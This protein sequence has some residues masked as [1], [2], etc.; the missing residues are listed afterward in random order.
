M[1]KR[2][3]LL[4]FEVICQISRPHRT[5][6]SLI[7]TCI[8]HFRTVSPAWFTNGYE[9]MHK[10]WSSIE[11]M[12]YYFS[13]SSAK[14]QGHTWQKK[15]ANFTQIGCFQ[16]VTPVWIHCCLRNGA[17]Y[18]TG[19]RREA[20]LFFKVIHQISKSSGTKI[21]LYWPKLGVSGLPLHFEFTNGFEMMHKAWHD[22]KELL[23]CFSKTSIEY[24]CH[25][26]KTLMIWIPFE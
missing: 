11:K 10:A 24:H 2:G 6:K 14:F 18:L 20:L 21:C 17:Q 7:L 22:I 26:G 25:T 23:Y 1:H 19:H 4:Y 9:M 5:E 15:S 12:L 13:R 3:A 16:T 8:W